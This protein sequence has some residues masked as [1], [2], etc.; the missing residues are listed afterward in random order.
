MLSLYNE[1]TA[2]M[3]QPLKLVRIKEE[4]SLIGEKKKKTDV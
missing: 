3:K 1:K 4:K 2:S